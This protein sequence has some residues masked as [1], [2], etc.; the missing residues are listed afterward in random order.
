M[1]QEVSVKEYVAITTIELLKKQRNEALD[2]LTV[3]EATVATLQR[4]LAQKEEEL[5]QLRTQLEGSRG[6]C[7]LAP[8]A[9]ESPEQ[10]P[11]V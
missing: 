9:S 4:L 10:P 5:N 2:R 11:Q 8:P 3:Q 6:S 1:D 7:T